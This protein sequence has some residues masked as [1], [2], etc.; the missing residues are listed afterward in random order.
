MPLLRL[1]N[2]P[3]TVRDVREVVEQ[4]IKD[5]S[6]RALDDYFGEQI[7]ELRASVNELAERLAEVLDA[8][9]AAKP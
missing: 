8:L 4:A 2:D 5:G 9:E 6:E 7:D 1:D 3:A